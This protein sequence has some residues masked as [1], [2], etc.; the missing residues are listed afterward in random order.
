MAINKKEQFNTE[1]AN[2][3]ILNTSIVFIKDSKEIWTHGQLYATQLTTAEIEAIVANSPSVEDVLAQIAAEVTARDKAVMAEKY[4][5]EQAEAA[6]SSSIESEIARSTAKDESHTA[7]INKEVQDRTNAIATEVTNRDAA[8]EVETNR[9]L[10]A[11]RTLQTNINSANT[12]INN[13][14]TRAT[15]AEQLIQTNLT[16]EVTRA[17]AAEQSLDSKITDHTNITDTALALKADKSDTYTKSQVDQ[18][19][20]GLYKVK[21][22]SKFEDLP[23]TNAVGD[24]YN[25]T[26]SFTLNEVVYPAGTNIVYTGNGWDAL[27]GVFDTTA[28]EGSIQTVAD[29]LTKE[30]VRA[31]EAE[32]ALSTSIANEVTNRT[33]ADTAIQSNITTLTNKVNANEIKLSTIQG[34]Y[35]TEG[36][37]NKA[38]EDA[39]SYT[40]SVV[41]GLD[42][43]V[44]DTDGNVSVSITETD[45]KLFN[46]DVNVDEAAMAS[47][48]GNLLYGATNADGL[49]S[50]VAGLMNTINNVFYTDI[51]S[52]NYS[53]GQ[54]LEVVKETVNHIVNKFP[55]NIVT[56]RVIHN[57]Q[58]YR[59]LYGFLYPS[60]SY[61]TITVR[62]S[63]GNIKTYL[64]NNY[65]YTERADNFGYN[66]LADLSAGVAGIMFAPKDTTVDA[67]EVLTFGLYMNLGGKVT[68]VPSNYGMLVSFALDYGKNLSMQHFYGIDG[69]FYTRTYAN[70]AWASWNRSDN[71][72]YNSL[73]ELSSGVA[74]LI[75][76]ANSKN[77]GLMPSKDVDI[78]H[79]VSEPLSQDTVYRIMKMPLYYKNI[80]VLEFGN[81]ANPT[82]TMVVLN[83]DNRGSSAGSSCISG[84]RISG[85]GV[86]YYEFD[87]N[88]NMSVYVK[89]LKGH[90]PCVSV[91]SIFTSFYEYPNT[92]EVVSKD[93]STLTVATISD[94]PF[95]YNTLTDLSSAVAGL[96]GG[97]YYNSNRSLSAIEGG[98]MYRVIRVSSWGRQAFMC[99]VGGAY[100]DSADIVSITANMYNTTPRISAY[101]S[102]YS[103]LKD[104]EF[105]YKVSNDVLEIYAYAAYSNVDSQCFLGFSS[106]KIEDLGI[107]SDLSGYTKIDV[108]TKVFGYNSLEELA[109]GLKP[110]LGLS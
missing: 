77:K 52:G 11:E 48:M 7:A 105:Y 64:I 102:N 62:P 83:V 24:T 88:N 78:R 8:I 104:V 13:E 75:P 87:S 103:S 37:I 63:D 49:A 56:F 15:E 43:T 17:K 97:N 99:S 66:T 29:S 57:K 31:K 27:S 107:V 3:N 73:A 79:Q 109:N 50:V 108:K 23:K 85:S 9:A 39:K 92:I 91:R 45:G 58:G 35:K 100:A 38:L 42:S 71:F 36:S 106:T 46:V 61:G 16:N 40:N 10:S 98:H 82:T 69:S 95:G 51:I 12:A 47:V 28:L 19:V 70:N 4:R 33:Q 65:E 101:R 53:M 22:S 5:A 2:N 94:G 110:L 90:Y 54:P 26:N 30:S 68:N 6:L 80:V 76:S 1:L 14:V 59:E 81:F 96:I 93:V 18:K 32:S 41:S 60:G 84:K 86:V 74:E 89:L 21:G 34:D 25:I 44:T 55:S 72:G 20:S 67:N